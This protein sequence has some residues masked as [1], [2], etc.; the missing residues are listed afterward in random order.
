MHFHKKN[1]KI[2]SEIHSYENVI[3]GQKD[4]QPLFNVMSLAHYIMFAPF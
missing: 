4:M 2:H 3:F 1:L